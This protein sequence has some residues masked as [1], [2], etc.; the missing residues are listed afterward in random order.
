MTDEL[1]TRVVEV[2]SLRA[3]LERVQKDKRIMA[4]L[5]TQMQ[6]DMTNKVGWGGEGGARPRP[7]SGN[8]PI[9]H[10]FFFRFV[11]IFK[12]V[13]FLSF[14]LSWSLRLRTV[15]SRLFMADL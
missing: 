12:H 7:G 1:Q 2:N 8:C 5:V 6:R 9:Y 11:V 14:F 3:E 13:I 15:M 10:S 4:G